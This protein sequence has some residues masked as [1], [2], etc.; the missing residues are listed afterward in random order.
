[1]ASN[2]GNTNAGTWV[3]SD[4]H[5]GFTTN[6]GS[7]NKD[8]TGALF[9]WNRGQSSW[10]AGF[11]HLYPITMFLGVILAFL[12]VAYFWKRMKYSWDTLYILVIIIVPTSIIGA[13]LWFLISS[14]NPDY[15][16]DWYKLEGLSIQGGVMASGLSASLYLWFQRHHI[17]FRTA[18]GIILPAVIVGQAIGRWGNFD[19]HEVYGAQVNG[20]SL[21]WLTFIKPHMLIN[22]T[23]TGIISYRQPF[24]FYESMI[25]LI[26]YLLLVWVL[27]RRNWVKPG[28]TGAMYLMYY[29]ITRIIMEPLRDPADI[30]KVNGFPMSVLIAAIWIAVGLI[31]FIWWQGLT[32]PFDK[33]AQ[34]IFPKKI[35]NKF[36]KEY[37]AIYPVK[38]RKKFFFG[39]EVETKG[40]ILLYWGKEVPNKVKLYVPVVKNEKWSKRE[41]NQGYKNKKK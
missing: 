12:T 21:N 9:A 8:T 37:K 25:N 28:A 11:L 33:W 31:L 6:F 26:G 4:G 36:K 7:V 13:R 29:G 35:L 14:G 39:E 38:P 41:I 18:A 17:D 24:F 2:Y 1:M 16:H 10:N 5:G 34:V 15:W 40:S 30:M 27:L 22:D 32:R 23:S 20:D 3:V 19:N